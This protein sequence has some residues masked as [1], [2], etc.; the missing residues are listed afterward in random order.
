MRFLTND[1][2]HGAL[3][4]LYAASQDIPG[5]SY[6]GPD[7]LGSIKGHPVVRRP[8]RAASDPETARA[9]WAATAELTGTGADT[10]TQRAATT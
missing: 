5:G 6:V 1:A 2:E 9:L 10:G 3:P 7:G 4:T 8:S